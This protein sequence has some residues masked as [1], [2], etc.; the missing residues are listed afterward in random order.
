MSDLTTLNLLMIA[1][2]WTGLLLML[3]DYFV[4]KNLFFGLVAYL[5]LALSSFLSLINTDSSILV[6]HVAILIASICFMISALMAY[7][8]LKEIEERVEESIK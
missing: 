8:R 5:F 2:I 3:F 6:F 1:L 7:K 4:F